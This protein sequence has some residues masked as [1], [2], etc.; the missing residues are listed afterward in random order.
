MNDHFSFIPNILKIAGYE[1]QVEEYERHHADARNNYGE[2]SDV[3]LKI[4]ITNSG[5]K[6][7]DLDTMIH[8]INHAIWWSYGI[9]N[10][11]KEERIVGMMSTAWAQIYLDNPWLVSYI[12]ETTKLPPVWA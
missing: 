5:F 4:R 7:R 2:F 3:E 9:E 12:A 11:D 10:G 6:H 1:V 8:E